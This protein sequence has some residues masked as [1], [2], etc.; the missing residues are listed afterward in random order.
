MKTLARAAII[1]AFLATTALAAQAQVQANTAEAAMFQATTLN[2]SAYGEV[3]VEPDMAMI[4]FGV[5]TEA[6]TAAAA[7]AQNARRMSEVMSA[8]QSQGIEARNVQTSS[9]NLNPQ[10]TYRENQAPLLRGYQAQNQVT[11]RVLDLER[12]GP[13]IDAVVNSGSNQINGISFG[14]ED[15][16]EAENQAR[17]EAVQA[18]RE[19]AQLY[20]QATGHSIRRLISLSEGGGYSQ[21]VPPP[22]PMLARAESFDAGTPVSS[23]E[24]TVRINVNGLYELNPSPAR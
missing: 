15:P 5:M 12:L 14:L 18:L 24:M 9:I 20:A 19:K 16:T 21:P 23:G 17:R 22:M 8:L 7:M 2:L 11:V 13:T 10:Y 1:G 3:R 4:N 6:P